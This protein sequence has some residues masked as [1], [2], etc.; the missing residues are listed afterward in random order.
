MLNM[1][2]FDLVLVQLQ[3]KGAFEYKHMEFALCINAL[4]K[5]S[6]ISSHTSSENAIN[7]SLAAFA[8][9]ACVLAYIHGVMLKPNQPQIR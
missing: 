8:L 7:N 2:T 1:L 6:C 3:S 4:T 5:N 9:R